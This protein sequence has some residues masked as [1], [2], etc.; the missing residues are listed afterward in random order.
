MF[1]LFFVIPVMTFLFFLFD[2]GRTFMLMDEEPVLVSKNES[3][4]ASP[5]LVER[6]DGEPMK[7]E[8]EEYV[9]IEHIPWTKRLTLASSIS[10]LSV[11]LRSYGGEAV[12]LPATIIS[13]ECLSSYLDSPLLTR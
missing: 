13:T 11:A 1:M 12:S 10:Y 8:Q 4:F 5:Y 7:Q 3:M 2:D 9:T 6:D